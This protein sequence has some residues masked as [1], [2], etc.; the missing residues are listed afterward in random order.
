[1]TKDLTRPS[2]C[3]INYTGV[4]NRLKRTGV[5]SAGMAGMRDPMATTPVDAT[6]FMWT[7][8]TCGGMPRFGAWLPPSATM[9]RT[10]S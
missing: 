4:R 7:A 5:S 10:Q 2:S 3:L 1:M 6:R 9:V 8:S